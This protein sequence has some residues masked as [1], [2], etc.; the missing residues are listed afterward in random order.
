MGSFRPVAGT[1]HLHRDFNFTESLVEIIIPVKMR[2]TRDRTER[3]H[4]ALL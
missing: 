3:P 2:V 4:G 1:L